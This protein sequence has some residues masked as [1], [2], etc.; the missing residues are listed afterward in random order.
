MFTSGS[1]DSK[2]PVTVNCSSHWFDAK[3]GGGLIGKKVKAPVPS[4]WFGSPT[5][6]SLAFQPHPTFGFVCTILKPDVD[7]P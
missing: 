4:A 6:D 2:A 1:V 3:D 5:Q 7:T